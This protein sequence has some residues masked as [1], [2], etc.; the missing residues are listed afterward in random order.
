MV[1]TIHMYTKAVQGLLSES[2]GL[3]HTAFPQRQEEGQFAT[4]LKFAVIQL[5]YMNRDSKSCSSQ[6]T[7]NSQSSV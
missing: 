1:L 3:E 6:K 7:L 5:R 4:L 2:T